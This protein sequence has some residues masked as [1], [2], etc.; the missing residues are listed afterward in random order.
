MEATDVRGL[1]WDSV[2]SVNWNLIGT[3]EDTSGK[4]GVGEKDIDILV[5]NIYRDV[6][7]KLDI[8]F[9]EIQPVLES[10]NKPFYRLKDKL[11]KQYNI[12]GKINQIYDERDQR[13]K[14]LQKTLRVPIKDDVCRC[15]ELFNQLSEVDK[16]KFL[17][18]IGKIKVKVDFE[19]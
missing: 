12:Y 19:E 13:L 2:K 9:E 5:E 1:L 14:A 15:Y 6:S 17:N 18:K 16:I 8:P 4:V 3:Q 11:F 7:R 10:E